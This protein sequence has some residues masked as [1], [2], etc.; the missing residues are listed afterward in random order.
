[1]ITQECL[2]DL[3]KFGTVHSLFGDDRAYPGFDDIGVSNLSLYAIA[4]GLRS[5]RLQ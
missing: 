1:M 5:T 3:L 4:S 2:Y